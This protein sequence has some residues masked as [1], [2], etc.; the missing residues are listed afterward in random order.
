MYWLRFTLLWMLVFISACGGS[1]SSS[2]TNQTTVQM[3]GSVQGKVLTLS[4]KV[5]T[6]AG[7]SSGNDGTGSSA[8]FIDPA[9]I[10]TDGTNL[11]VTCKDNTIRKV[12]IATGEVTTLAGTPGVY[13]S[14]DG[15]GAAASFNWPKGIV[16]DGPNL[17]VA[18]SQNEKIRKIVIA[19]GQVSTLAGNGNHGSVDGVGTGA[20]FSIPTQMTTD[21]TNLY[22]QENGYTGAFRK[23]EIATG[24]VTTFS[25]NQVMSGAMTT[26]GKTVFVADAPSI[27]KIDIATGGISSQLTNTGT[28]PYVV[29]PAGLTMV[30]ANIFF[31]DGQDFTVRKVDITSGLVT[32]IAGKVGGSGVTDGIGS[33]ARF[34]K[35][36]SITSDG[37]NLYVIDDR[38]IRKV[39]IAT[40]E[41]TTL[42]G[43]MSTSDD[44]VGQDARFTYP[45]GI[46]T[47]GT[48]LY[49][50]DN[51]I[52][53]KIVI[54]SGEVST[55]KFNPAIIDP[56]TGAAGLS[57]KNITTDGINLYV[58][59]TYNY[60]IYKI[61]AATG[62]VTPFVGTYSVSGSVDGAGGQA[63]FYSP[64][65]ITADGKS[66]YVV[67]TGSY[68]VRK[69]E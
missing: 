44:G 52:I 68:T 22:V 13:G 8:R 28:P 51:Y 40:G 20:G 49:T 21:G 27:R 17:Y 45:G 29:T 7:A 50:T 11:Y 53:R 58:T 6:F 55:L 4:Q 14:A 47:D 23:V 39:V 19:T 31:T 57:A 43:K 65:G 64:Y 41:V 36:M 42:A 38:A 69:V 1:S 66:L 34:L 37:T 33:E 56:L 54:A 32:T 12:V 25:T 63:R 5:T 67:D 61:V 46:T 30:G 60:I 62:E 9:G 18:D 26:D 10:T 48:T 15:T 24:T 2:S 3:G 16:T 59:S 35:P